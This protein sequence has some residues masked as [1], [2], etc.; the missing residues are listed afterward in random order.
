MG[1]ES[2]NEKDRVQS[3]HAEDANV[4]RQAEEGQHAKP[5]TVPVVGNRLTG[6]QLEAEIGP[7][8]GQSFERAEGREHDRSQ[9]AGADSDALRVQHSGD[10]AKEGMD[11]DRGDQTR[12]SVESIIAQNPG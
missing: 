6:A 1:D 4:L 8:P 3:G 5:V 10:S 7:E 12:A 11:L 2:G 9:P